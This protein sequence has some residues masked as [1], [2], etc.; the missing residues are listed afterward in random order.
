[1]LVFDEATAA[2]D[3]QTEAELIRAIARLEGHKT[4][5]IVAHRL[6]MV[7]HCDRLV[8]LQA[9]RLID[10]GPPAELLARQAELR[11]VATSADGTCAD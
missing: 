4:L 6:S 11:R 5:L 3:H 8:F 2:L 9:G 7:R 10:C 1:M